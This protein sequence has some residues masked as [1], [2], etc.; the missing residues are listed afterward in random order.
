MR[1]EDR[2]G[3][4]EWAIIFWICLLMVFLVW[5]TWTIVRV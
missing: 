2:E 3:L 1:R 5:K 4:V